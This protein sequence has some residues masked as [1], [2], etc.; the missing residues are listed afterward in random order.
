M[1]ENLMDGLLRQMNRCRELIAQYEMIGP[2]G[3]FG[4]AVIKARITA[5]EKAIS[6][7]DVAEMVSAYKG[8]E[9][10]E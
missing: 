2:S 7:N 8:L 6:S 9:G 10:C 4:K 1:S 3:A 5:A